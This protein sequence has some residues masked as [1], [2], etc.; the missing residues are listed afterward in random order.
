MKVWRALESTPHSDSRIIPI[1]VN[2]PQSISSSSEKNSSYGFS[3]DVSLGANR[4][5]QRLVGM[6]SAILALASSS[7][8]HS[9]GSYPSFCSRAIAISANV[10]SCV[11]R[12]RSGEKCRPVLSEDP[13]QQAEL[14][15]LLVRHEEAL[16]VIGRGYRLALLK[17]LDKCERQAPV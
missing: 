8:A 17:S 13:R 9:Y 3:P 6:S 15:S 1:E 12:S 16:H 4:Q 11:P 7:D 5:G 2:R 14:A 10:R